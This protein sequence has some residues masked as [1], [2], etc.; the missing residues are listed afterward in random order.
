MLTSLCLKQ[1]RWDRWHQMCQW[2]T[3]RS[4]FV[5]RRRFVS[6][7]TDKVLVHVIFI[8]IILQL[9][10]REMSITCGL[11]P[12]DSFIF[13]IQGDWI[14]SIL[15]ITWAVFPCLQLDVSSLA[16][17]Y[18]WGWHGP[19]SSNH[20][21]NTTKEKQPPLSSQSIGNP[22]KRSDSLLSIG[23]FPYLFS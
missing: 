22:T 4:I 23:S 9:L 7:A 17:N 16:A 14:D 8:L 5:V 10:V 3:C 20:I 11:C 6:D 18:G 15:V 21:C 1:R 2:E 12:C 19:S 13:K